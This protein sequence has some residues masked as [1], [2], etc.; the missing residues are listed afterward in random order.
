MVTN[1]S[2][3]Y[4]YSLAYCLEPIPGGGLTKAEMEA[5]PKYGRAVREREVG[6]VR[7]V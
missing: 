2:T 6:V 1:K 4:K 7:A 5:H 3:D